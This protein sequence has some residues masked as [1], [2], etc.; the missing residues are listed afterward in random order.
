MWPGCAVLWHGVRFSR[1][2][3]KYSI[4]LSGEATLGVDTFLSEEHTFQEQTAL[5]ASFEPLVRSL[6]EMESIEYF[7]MFR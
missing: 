5:V 2:A 4:L 7:D 3:A 1:A 6:A